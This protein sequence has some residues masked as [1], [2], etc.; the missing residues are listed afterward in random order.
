[1]AEKI[2]FVQYEVSPEKDTELAQA[3]GG[4]LVS[5]WIRASS[6]KTAKE[7]FKAELKDT[8]WKIYQ[9]E[10]AYLV[11]NK[12]YTADEEALLFYQQALDDDNVFYI[13]AWPV[14]EQ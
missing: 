13:D 6:V 10:D 2:V 4:A 8:G 1:M 7:I 9:F 11:D 3:Y 12:H 14:D 5:A